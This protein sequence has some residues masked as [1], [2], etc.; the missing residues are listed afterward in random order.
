[1]EINIGI[2]FWWKTLKIL[3][4]CYLR[5]AVVSVFIGLLRALRFEVYMMYI[6]IGIQFFRKARF[7]KR[8]RIFPWQFDGDLRDALKVNF[9]VIPGSRP[10]FQMRTPILT[11]LKKAENFMLKLISVTTLIVTFKVISSP[12]SFFVSELNL[13]W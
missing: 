11:D 2:G 9:K 6:S 5:I 7:G 8:F 13:Y 3:G 12:N 1:M 4:Y 10:F